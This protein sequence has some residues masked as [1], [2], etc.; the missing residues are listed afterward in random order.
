MRGERLFNQ[1]LY[2]DE[3]ATSFWHTSVMYEMRNVE[4]RVRR[5]T[6]AEA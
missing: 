4:I 2:D 3:D 6:L 5:P 1:R